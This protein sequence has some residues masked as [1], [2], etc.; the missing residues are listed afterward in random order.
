M[1]NT[2]R[3][4][5]RTAMSIKVQLILGLMIVAEIYFG[6]HS[7]FAQSENELYQALW[8]LSSVSMFSVFLPVTSFFF[9]VI[10]FSLN[11][12][13]ELP[14]GT[15]G[16]RIVGFLSPESLKLGRVRLCPSYWKAIMLMTLLVCASLVASMAVVKVF[17]E[18][19]GFDFMGLCGSVYNG[20]I[21]SLPVV[22]VFISCLV[23]LVA[24]FFSCCI[25]PK[26]MEKIVPF[27]FIVST[28]ASFLQVI[29]S[30]LTREPSGL[31]HFNQFGYL[32][33][34]SDVFWTGSVAFSLVLGVHYLYRAFCFVLIQS[35]MMA[36]AN[37]VL[38]VYLRAVYEK[39]CP[40][41]ELETD[42]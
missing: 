30:I 18:V 24:L 4:F 19:L 29:L 41:I 8:N 23:F 32:A 31:S 20:V 13:D 17:V 14:K 34:Y 21:Y 16:Y 33:T 6:A 37:S 9:F 15:L 11:E 36:I 10:S 38:P 42:E 39:A 1:A 28:G 40:V 26:E 27:A 22:S 7:Y 3:Q 5:L 2:A 25:F 12:Y 35:Y